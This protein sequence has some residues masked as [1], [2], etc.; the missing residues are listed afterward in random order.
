MVP[1]P[2]FSF[3]CIKCRNVTKFYKNF[4][5]FTTTVPL[6]QTATARSRAFSP[7][8]APAKK[9]GSGSTTLLIRINLDPFNTGKIQ[10]HLEFNK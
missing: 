2:T 9:S 4:S 5:Y 7:A 6:S 10:T 8:P 1:V 3:L